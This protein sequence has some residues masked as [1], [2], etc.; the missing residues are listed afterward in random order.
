[1]KVF[2]VNK[3]K[4]DDLETINELQEYI[5]WLQPNSKKLM[6]LVYGDLHKILKSY[7]F[8]NNKTWGNDAKEVVK[9][10][11]TDLFNPLCMSEV[12]VKTGR[13][14]FA[15]YDIYIRMMWEATKKDPKRVLL[16]RTIKS[17]VRYGHAQWDKNK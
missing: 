17:S 10:T 11:L 1:M 15:I 12:V 8:N 5:D 2:S 7:C 14:P 6:W 9:R 13:T 3:S 4:V 16:K